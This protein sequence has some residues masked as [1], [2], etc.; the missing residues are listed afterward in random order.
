MKLTTHLLLVLRLRTYGAIPLLLYLSIFTKCFAQDMK[1]SPFLIS[2]HNTVA[3]VCT[4]DFAA[5]IMYFPVKE[6]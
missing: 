2:I 3:G 4:I 1:L 6:I 5:Y